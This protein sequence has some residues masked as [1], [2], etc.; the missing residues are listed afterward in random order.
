MCAIFEHT[1]LRQHSRACCNTIE[2]CARGRWLSVSINVSQD[3][4]GHDHSRPSSAHDQNPSCLS[5]PGFGKLN[6]MR[7]DRRAED[8]TRC[9]A[10]CCTSCCARR[11]AHAMDRWHGSCARLA[12]TA[13]STPRS[14][15]S[16]GCTCIC[17]PSMARAFD[18][19]RACASRGQSTSGSRTIAMGS[20]AQTADAVRGSIGENRW[21]LSDE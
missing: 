12:C 20:C 3:A 7:A 13:S 9:S 21:W 8:G 2:Q 18:A 15:T 10:C 5:G 14:P 6:R 16:P 1:D 4:S 11:A 19:V 17:R